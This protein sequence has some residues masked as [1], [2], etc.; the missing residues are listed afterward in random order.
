MSE[1][2]AAI[3]AFH[4]L[5]LTQPYS[6]AFTTTPNNWKEGLMGQV[7]TLG[8]PFRKNETT[9]KRE[10]RE[11]ERGGGGRDPQT[12]QRHQKK[13][14]RL[15]EDQPSLA[16]SVHLSLIVKNTVITVVY[17]PKPSSLAHF[18]QIHS[19]GLTSL[20]SHASWA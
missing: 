14:P 6:S 2:K 1:V 11:T 4:A 3:I 19:T 8:T 16:N 9:I 13:L 18:L 10:W 15:S 20:R 5:C 7:P 17:I 12:H